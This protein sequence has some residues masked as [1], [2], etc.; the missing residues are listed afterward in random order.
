[1]LLLS[2]LSSHSGG[3]T[4]QGTSSCSGGG[5]TQ[6]TWT[7]SQLV[8]PWQ[9]GL[10]CRQGGGPRSVVVGMTRMSLSLWW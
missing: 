9:H 5:T 2:S 1:M 10:D 7:S 6:G 3:S 8:L 4:A